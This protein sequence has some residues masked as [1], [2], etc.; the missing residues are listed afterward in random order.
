V[1]LWDCNGG[2]N[3]S[4]TL[5]P[6]RRLEVYGTKCLD[7]RDGGTGNGTV[8]QI[9]DCTGAAAQQWTV[10]S[11]GSVV[12]AGS[13]RCLDATS[14]GTANG[15][16]IELWDCTGGANQQW[17]RGPV[18]SPLRGQESGRCVDVPAGNQASGT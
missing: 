17:A 6:D 14:N 11:D 9:N 5:T 2:A 18:A 7:A 4:W 15:T 16:A 10:D 3:Q 8:V 13:G 1:D 12:N